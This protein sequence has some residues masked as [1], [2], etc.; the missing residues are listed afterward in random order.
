MLFQEE[1][2][3]EPLEALL[4]W[5]LMVMRQ[6]P[7]GLRAE[8]LGIHAHMGWVGG[9]GT[10]SISQCSGLSPHQRGG[11]CPPPPANALC[12]ERTRGLQSPSRHHHVSSLLCW[13]A[14]C[15]ADCTWGLMDSGLVR[16]GKFDAH[17]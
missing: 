17:Y 8:I 7:L 4:F 3:R 5:G 14:G 1:K 10:V 9:L 6:G 12:L 15:G 13:A 11:S 16:G 2:E